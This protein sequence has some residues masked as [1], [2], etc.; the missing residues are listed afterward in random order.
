MRFICFNGYLTPAVDFGV[1][2]FKR[3]LRYVYF[4]SFF[5]Q[6]KIVIR[7]IPVC[8]LAVLDDN[9]KV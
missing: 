5:R 3:A 7:S 6:T 1:D 9:A 2:L 8:L 4:A